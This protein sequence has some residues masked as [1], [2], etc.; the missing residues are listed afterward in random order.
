M[1]RI[2]GIHQQAQPFY[3]L[4]YR[5]LNPGSHS[6]LSKHSTIKKIP[7]PASFYCL[8]EKSVSL[9]W[10]EMGRTSILGVPSIARPYPQASIQSQEAKLF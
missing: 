3:F 8:I 1:S 6:C 9:L 5:R 10:G 4:F 7:C 2:T